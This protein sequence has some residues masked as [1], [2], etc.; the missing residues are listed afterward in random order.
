MIRSLYSTF[1]FVTLIVMVVSALF[2]FMLSN[3]YYQHVLKQQNDEKYTKISLEIVNYIEGKEQINLHEHLELIASI[4]YQIKL[5]GQDGSTIFFGK[6][7]RSID[8]DPQIIDHVLK[9]EIYH[10]IAYFPRET[11]VTGFFA[12]ELENSIGVSFKHKERE[13]A[14]FLRPDLTLHFNEMRFLFAWL[15]VLTIIFSL[16]FE[17]ILAKYLIQPLSKLNEATKKIKQGDFSLTLDFKRNDEIGELAS[18]FQDMSNQLGKLDDMR[19]EFISNI[20]HDIQSPLSNINGY[21]EMLRKDHLTSE[22]K[23]E[24]LSI[25]REESSRLSSLT[26]QLLLLSSINQITELREKKRFS[27]SNQIISLI[28]KYK[29]KL[30]DKEIAIQYSL[31]NTTYTGDESLLL[32]VWENLLSNAVKYNKKGGNITLEI[33][34]DIEYIYVVFQDSGI[35]LSTSQQKNI[36]ERFYRADSSRTKDVEG[37]GLGL[38]IASK[39]VTLHNGEILV[40]SGK[41]VGTTFTVRLPKIKM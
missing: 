16:F 4:G 30:L 26:S 33:K 40:E 21:T 34:E 14:L 36:F 7:F 35:G 2:A 41:G 15:L 31:P 11:F 28:S 27:I 29:W 25:I 37:S 8:I 18:S 24:Y 22:Q 3:A 19:N 12:N 6:P 13:Y 39:V 9:G 38:A 17:L 1:V 20:S 5:T 10:G 23:E 32:S